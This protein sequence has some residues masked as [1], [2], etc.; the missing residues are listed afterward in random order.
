MV[1]IYCNNIAYSTTIVA[2]YYGQRLSIELGTK[3]MEK[4]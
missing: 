4:L 1:L 3:Q 2:M